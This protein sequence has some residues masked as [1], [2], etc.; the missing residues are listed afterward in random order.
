MS[1][2][3]KKPRRQ[4]T[5]KSCL[6]CRLKKLKCDR[7][8]PCS[9]C[10]ER[11]VEDRCFYETPSDT[12]LVTNIRP[13][14]PAEETHDT[15][16]DLLTGEKFHCYKPI[17]LLQM[18]E[19]SRA[20][21]RL[22]FDY[23]FP[24]VS[25]TSLNN[26]N[27]YFNLLPPLTVSEL[28]FDLYI[29][30]FDT[31]F[32]IIDRKVIR[33]DMHRLVSASSF[34]HPGRLKLILMLFHYSLTIT[35]LPEAI[36]KYFAETNDSA[37]SLSSRIKQKM[38]ELE[39]FRVHTR[40][41]PDVYY[42]EA[43]V[44]QTYYSFLTQPPQQLNLDLCSTIHYATSIKG[45]TNMKNQ[46]TVQ[47]RYKQLWT[48]LCQLD[49]MVAVLRSNNPWVQ[50][51]W[52]GQ[53]IPKLEDTLADEKEWRYQKLL[54]QILEFGLQVQK[55]HLS[56]SVEKFT[57][58]NEDFNVGI[59][60]F[61]LQ[62]ENCLNMTSNRAESFRFEIFKL[63]LFRI[64]TNIYRYYPFTDDAENGKYEYQFQLLGSSS[65][66]KIEHTISIFDES[67]SFCW[68][69]QVS[70]QGL[71]SFSSMPI[72]I[73]HNFYYQDDLTSHISFFL[74]QRDLLN[75]DSKICDL[76]GEFLRFLKSLQNDEEYESLQQITRAGDSAAFDLLNTWLF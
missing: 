36:E 51:E 66:R 20:M 61:S 54:G 19:D 71:E 63:L 70:I 75:I 26:P 31:V 39:D 1:F 6:N 38:E 41:L 45:L 7:C 8:L 47:R 32:P 50:H 37:K 64:K 76:L 53:L 25:S 5:K 62:V 13:L 23:F 17:V 72:C 42:L 52:D 29:E 11:H 27:D 9:R 65:M 49:A 58:K 4:R 74:Q 44:V 67:K 73:K 30:R 10:K 34:P 15:E 18:A 46:P 33:E 43:S 22:F 16:A 57:N 59:T 60:Q 35:D 68:M 21:P 40:H 55:D 12:R 56:L 3:V 14:Q 28:I 69:R 2:N 48:T 24:K